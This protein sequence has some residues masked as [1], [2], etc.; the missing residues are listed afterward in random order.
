MMSGMDDGRG[1][2]WKGGGAERDDDG[3]EKIG[4]LINSQKHSRG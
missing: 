2:E 4:A 1:E 3:E